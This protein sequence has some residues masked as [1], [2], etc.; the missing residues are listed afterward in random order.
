MQCAICGKEV[1][2]DTLSKDT[3]RRSIERGYCYCSKECLH[4]KSSITMR[5]TNLSRKDILSQKMKEHN[6]MFNANAK[7]KMIHTLKEIGHH[8]IVRGGNGKG[9]TIPQEQ[10]FTALKNQIDFIVLTEYVVATKM[11]NHSGYPPCYK[12]DIAIPEIKLAIEVDGGSHLALERKAQD[13]KKTEFLN[14]LGWNV[15]RF[16]NQEVMNNLD[17]CIKTIVS[18]I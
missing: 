16:K 11:K 14:G 12:I 15:L 1:D 9:L 8:P 10:L 4:K 18:T 5:N 6:P 2:L 7:N 17:S 13:K 3:K